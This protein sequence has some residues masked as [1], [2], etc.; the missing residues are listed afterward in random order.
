MCVGIFSF[1][2]ILVTGVAWFGVPVKGSLPLLMV[3]NFLFLLTVLAIGIVIS[4]ISSTQLQA[5]QAS[6]A[7]ILPS[8]L[9]SGFIFPRETMP[10]VIRLL[11]SVIPLTYILDILRGIFLKAIGIAELWQDT[12]AL[13]AFTAV[14]C[15][16]AIVRFRKNWSSGNFQ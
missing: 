13:S 12:L 9:L 2:I 5:M 10:W 8:V 15:A 6:F 1:T 3:L 4:T 16:I 14:L 11:S 7:I